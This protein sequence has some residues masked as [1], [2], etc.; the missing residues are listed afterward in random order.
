MLEGP[1]HRMQGLSSVSKMRVTGAVLSTLMF[2]TRLALADPAPEPKDRSTA[3]LLS[4]GGTAASLSLVLAGADNSNEWL[5][6]AGLISSLF[7]PA[8]GRIYAGCLFTPGLGIR[9]VSAGLA[10]AAFK[11]ALDDEGNRGN[12]ERTRVLFFAG[13]IGYA[14]GIVYDI[15]TVGRAVDDYNQ[16]LRLHVTPTVIPTASSGPAVGLGIGGSF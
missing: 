2:T 8:A 1:E 14:S 12:N 15:A 3:F 16:R 10:V 13:V 9:L 11:E 4:L 5:L 6:G 7:T